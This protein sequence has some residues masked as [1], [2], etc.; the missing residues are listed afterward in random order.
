MRAVNLI[1]ADER[2]GVRAPSRAGILS[3]VLV[4]GLLLV[5]A[6]ITSLVMTSNSIA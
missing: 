2:R 3:Y 5:L 1:P 6:G 4:G